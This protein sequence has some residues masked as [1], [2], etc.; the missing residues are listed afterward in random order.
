MKTLILLILTHLKFV[1]SCLTLLIAMVL[2][3]LKS[4][5][6]LSQ[7]PR[8][9]PSPYVTLKHANIDPECAVC[10]KCVK[11]YNLYYICHSVTIKYNK[12]KLESIEFLNCFTDSVIYCS[13][14]PYHACS[15]LNIFSI[16]GLSRSGSSMKCSKSIGSRSIA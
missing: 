15:C 16:W 4:P 1:L 7:R 2:L 9:G 14:G 13:V 3:V 8:I 10:F 11:I 12:K 6:F 5:H